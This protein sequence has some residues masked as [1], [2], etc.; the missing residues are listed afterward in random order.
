[1]ASTTY[2]RPVSQYVGDTPT[3]LFVRDVS[4]WPK[5]VK[6]VDTPLLNL[7]KTIAPPDKPALKREWGISSPDP[8]NDT[9]SVGITSVIP[10]VTPTNIGY[11]QV[12]NIIQID[13]EQMLVTAVGATD[14]T[15]LRGQF[16]TVAAAHVNTALLNGIRIISIAVAE[17]AESPRGVVTQGELDFNF[18]QIWD[19]MVQHSHRADVTPTYEY[20]NAGRSAMEVQKKLSTTLPNQMENQ[21]LFGQRSI[22][23]TTAPST[24]G[25]VFQ[26]SFIYTKVDAAG[27]ALTEYSFLS[28]MQTAYQ[29]VG[30][31]MIGKTV[32]GH[33]LMKRI[34]GSWYAGQRH[35]SFSDTKINVTMDEIVTDFGTFKF[36]MN[37]KMTSIANPLVGDGRLLAFD[38]D[39]YQLQPYDAKAKWG[40][41]DVYE[42]GWYKRRAIRGDY[43]LLAPNPEKRVSF[44]NLSVTDTDYA[45][46]VAA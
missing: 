12:G 46:L 37:Y 41:W 22:G 17:N 9:L 26:S 20:R 25:G 40:V 18:C 2:N 33:P 16:G 30:G 11:Y 3:D 10:T 31:N 7:I 13:S 38:P 19:I 32:M 6:R 4:N 1:M 27:A 42:G 28:A 24:M 29:A 5:M 43:T 39:D 36:V 23:S 35:G 21:L 44:T 14:L 15:V 34:F 8:E 45:S